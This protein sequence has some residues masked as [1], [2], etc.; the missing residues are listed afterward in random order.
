[1]TTAAVYC[2]V[3]TTDQ[4]EE[5]TSLDTQRDQAMEKAREL[6]WAVPED[7]VIQEDWTGKDLNRPGL[8]RLLELSSSGKIQGVV[9][10][11]MDRLYRPEND[12]DEWRVFELLQRLR[13]SNVEVAWVDPS[14]PVTGPLSSIFTFLDAWRSGRER[15]AILERTARGRLEK[16]RRGQVVSSGAA[17]FGYRFDSKAS[18]LVIDDSEAEIVR[19]IFNMYNTERLS[20]IK[21]A[22]QLNRLGIGRPDGGRRW[23]ASHL[24]RMLRS[25]TYAGVLWQNRWESASTSD[26]RAVRRERP[27]SEQI[28]TD[29]PAIVTRDVFEAVQRRL[30]RNLRHARRNAKREYLLSGLLR[31]AC[32]SGMG[33]RTRRGSTYYR[34]FK[35]ETSKADI[36]HQGHP[37]PCS[38]QWVNAGN[39]E[40]GVWDSVTRLLR[41]PDLLVEEIEKMNQPDSATKKAVEADLAHVRKRLEAI[42]G[43]EMRLVAGYR[44]GYYSDSVM[45]DEKVRVDKKG[46]R[47]KSVVWS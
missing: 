2:R 39:L 37:Q 23:R 26:G 32:G 36:D 34:C 9:I 15:R 30:D 31:H 16:A 13:D 11:T 40:T 12:G 18:A 42:P 38:C 28:S 17:P 46:S 27:K 7:Y 6:G 43:E 14:I 25:E 22:D 35:S 47:R 8:V 44:K 33:G 5:G 3:S 1:M 24:G 45:R 4:R 21:L 20:L 19:T 41:N 10:F 29:V